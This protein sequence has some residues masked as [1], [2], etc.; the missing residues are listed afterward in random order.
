MAGTPRWCAECSHHYPKDAASSLCGL[1]KCTMKPAFHPDGTDRSELIGRDCAGIQGWRGKRISDVL[2]EVRENYAR[3]DELAAMTKKL[4]KRK[5]T[6]KKQKPE[7]VPD[8]F[9]VPWAEKVRQSQAV[10]C[11]PEAHNIAECNTIPAPHGVDAQGVVVIPKVP[12]NAMCNACVSWPGCTKAYPDCKAF[13]SKCAFCVKNAVC[14]QVLFQPDWSCYE[15]RHAAPDPARCIHDN[16]GMKTCR[17]TG[18]QC[19][20]TCKDDT[21]KGVG[22]FCVVEKHGPVPKKKEAR[23]SLDAFL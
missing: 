5:P 8:K 7:N 19:P 10:G 4:T 9:D 11:P 22:E 18:K 6:M 17:V 13:N 20:G 15:P 16:T 2:G 21:R 1:R 23:M 14:K 3:A 12:V